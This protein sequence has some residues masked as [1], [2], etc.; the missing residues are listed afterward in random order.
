MNDGT[1]AARG[2]PAAGYGTAVFRAVLGGVFALL[3]WS[4]AAQWDQFGASVRATSV[5]T[6]A[7]VVSID[8]YRGNRGYRVYTP[9][10]RFNTADGQ[11]VEAQSAM[12]YRDRAPPYIVTQRV[13]VLYNA[14][15]P[16]IVYPAEL[17]EGEWAAELV[18]LMLFSGVALWGLWSA[19]SI[20][21]RLRRERQAG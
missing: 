21:L 10:F 1:P 19:G 6:V 20:V 11:V 15:R 2:R 3:G 18:W 12:P 17:I 5:R 4:V 14:Q 16:E 7:E 13:P 8:L 9:H